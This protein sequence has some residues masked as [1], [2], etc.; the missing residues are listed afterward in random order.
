MLTAQ[1]TQEALAKFQSS[2]QVSTR[3]GSIFAVATILCGNYVITYGLGFFLETC[4]EYLSK[5]RCKGGGGVLN[6]CENSSKNMLLSPR[7]QLCKVL[8]SPLRE[9]LKKKLL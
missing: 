7:Q 4:V 5:L 3:T 6:L 9:G 2:Q 8:R 1:V